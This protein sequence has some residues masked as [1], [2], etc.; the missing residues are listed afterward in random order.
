MMQNQSTFNM[1]QFYTILK[2]LNSHLHYYTICYKGKKIYESDLDEI[3][4]S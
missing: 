3:L 2:Y 4:L 1:H